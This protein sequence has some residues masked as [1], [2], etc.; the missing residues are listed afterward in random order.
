MRAY[1][2]G[3]GTVRTVLDLATALSAAAGAPAPMVTGLA[4]PTDVRH[5]TASSERAARELGWRATEDFTSSVRELL[6]EPRRPA[7]SASPRRAG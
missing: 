5:I 4:R 3:S 7:T 6:S 1:N 2:V